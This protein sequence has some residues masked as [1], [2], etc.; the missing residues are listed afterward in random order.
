MESKE[1][2]LELTL[3]G[4]LPYDLK[5][6]FL[7]SDV[8]PEAKYELRDKSLKATNL[9]FFMKYAKPHLH[10]L[11]KLT[12]P[13]LPNGEIPIVELAK[14]ASLFDTSEFTFEVGTDE[15]GFWCNIL[16][17]GCVKDCMLFDGRLFMNN[18]E[19]TNLI[20]YSDIPNQLELFEKLKE[21]HFNIYNLDKD[22]YLEKSEVKNSNQ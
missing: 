20:S 6:S 7:V 18:Y 4:M 9:D 22:Q 13:I 19:M 14:I 15:L 8:V 16:K 5:G 2:R 3:C 12:E 21:W 11:D 1:R 17:N 10:S